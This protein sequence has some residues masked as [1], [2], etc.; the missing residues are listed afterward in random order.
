MQAPEAVICQLFP[1]LLLLP[2]Q[3]RRKLTRIV[4]KA[5]FLTFWTI[6]F[7]HGKNF[8][9]GVQSRLLHK[10]VFFEWNLDRKIYDP[11]WKK[12][13]WNLEVNRIILHHRKLWIIIKLRQGKK[14]FF[15]FQIAWKCVTLAVEILLEIIKTVVTEKL[16]F[17]YRDCLKSKAGFG[18]FDF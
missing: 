14:N 12:L 3:L 5:F 1:L 16:I 11:S 9:K 2:F 6:I 18:L 17:Q 7:G 13:S 4:F 8:K 10:C 15:S